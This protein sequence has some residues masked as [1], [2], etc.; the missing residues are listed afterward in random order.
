[1]LSLKVGRF[2]YSSHGALLTLRPPDATDKLYTYTIITTDSNAQLSF[3]HDRMPVIL[4]PGSTSLIAWLSPHQS[5]WSKDLQSLLKPYAGELEC[6]P[7]PREVGKVGNNSPSFVV[8]IDSAENKQNIANFF[9][10]QKRTAAT[11][12][13]KMETKKVESDLKDHGDGAKGQQQQ[14]NRGT[15]DEAKES[16]DIAPKPTPEPDSKSAT[17]GTKRGRDD[18]IEDEDEADEEKPHKAPKMASPA[19]VIRSTQASRTKTSD[20]KK[21]GSSRPMRSATKNPSPTKPAKS[22]SKAED[23]S[24]KITN[25]FGT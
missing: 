12:E 6:Y 8:P 7:V 19:K 5:S 18:A 13:A 22:A 20:T 21:Q 11:K 14:D 24:K 25:F 10:N 23:G 15:T 4:D 1:M 2:P 17:A 3:L 16:E 9:G